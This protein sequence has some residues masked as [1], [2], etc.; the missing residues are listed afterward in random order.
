MKHKSLNDLSESELAELL[1]NATKELQERQTGKRKEVISEIKALAASIGIS[2]ELGDGGSA[3]GSSRRGAKVAVKYRNPDN[4]L[5]TWTGRGV[6]PK[7]L[8]ALIDQGRNLEEFV[9]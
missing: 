6:R 7:W 4:H 9:V 1:Q 3:K 2:V 5:E 8:K